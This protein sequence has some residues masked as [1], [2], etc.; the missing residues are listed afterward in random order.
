[1]KIGEIISFAI[2][3][4][5]IAVIGSFAFYMIDA[6]IAEFKTIALIIGIESLASILSVG[7]SYLYLQI[8]FLKKINEGE[9]NQLN[10]VERHSVLNVVSKIFMSVHLLVGLCV[11]GVYIAVQ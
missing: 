3:V 6:A 7:V 9:D 8:P 2:T 10:S 1:M 5:I 11:L 4:L